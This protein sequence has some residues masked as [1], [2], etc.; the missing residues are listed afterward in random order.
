[1]ELAVLLLGAWLGLLLFGVA[2]RGAVHLVLVSA[3]ALTPWRELLGPGPSPAGRR[4][5][6]ADS[7]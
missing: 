4:P 2:L 3:L 5:E 7:D 1:M 6:S